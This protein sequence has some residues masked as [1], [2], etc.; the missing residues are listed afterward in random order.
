MA[1]FSYIFNIAALHYC[2][3]YQ[4]PKHDGQI[5]SLHYLFPF[6]SHDTSGKMAS[7]STGIQQLLA[8]EKR[9]AEKV[10]EARKSKKLFTF[11][12]SK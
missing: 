2:V 6:I 4:A 12:L 10:A 3:L 1:A 5:N 9:A 7:Q 8:A 11:L